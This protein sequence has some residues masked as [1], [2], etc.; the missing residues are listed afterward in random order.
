[1]VTNKIAPEISYRG[2]ALPAYD[3]HHEH[4][5]PPRQAELTGVSL[6]TNKFDE[7]SKGG[8]RLAWARI[9]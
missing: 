5:H 9:G 4:P 7:Y 6:A 2:A 8:L 1:M 3:L